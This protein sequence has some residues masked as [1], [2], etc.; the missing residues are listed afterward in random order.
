[1]IVDFAESP[2][3]RKEN[4]EQG[5]SK[6]A[7]QNA[8]LNGQNVTKLWWQVTKHNKKVMRSTE[9]NSHSFKFRYASHA[10]TLSYTQTDRVVGN[11]SA[12]AE[13]ER[14]NIL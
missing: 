9:R 3:E 4:P 7:H 6:Q 13:P 5:Q 11:L 10:N 8:Q 2:P 14:N 1:M 12:L